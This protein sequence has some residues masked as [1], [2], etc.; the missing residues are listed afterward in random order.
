MTGDLTWCCP[1]GN[2]IGGSERA[3]S[4]LDM[5]VVTANRGAP[6]GVS[7][8]FANCW[9]MRP[10]NPLWGRRS[11]PRLEIAQNS[12][13]T[14]GRARLARKQIHVRGQGNRIANL[15]TSW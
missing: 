4:C 5:E 11:H 8:G 6:S 2:F 9:K 15:A 14:S 10:A 3:S 12:A 7:R 1:T 13:S